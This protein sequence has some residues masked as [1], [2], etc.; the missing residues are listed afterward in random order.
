MNTPFWG[1]IRKSLFSRKVKRFVF[2]GAVLV[3]LPRG[4]VSALG[5]EMER[6]S[7]E[8]H[9]SFAETDFSAPPHISKYRQC[10]FRLVEAGFKLASLSLF[11]HENRIESITWYQLRRDTVRQV[12]YLKGWGYIQKNDPR[13]FM[14]NAKLV[15]F[16]NVS[17]SFVFNDAPDFGPSIKNG[18]DW[19]RYVEGN[20]EPLWDALLIHG[21]EPLDIDPVINTES[22]VPDDW[23]L[24]VG[25]TTYE[26]VGRISAVFEKFNGISVKFVYG[27]P[28][29]QDVDFDKLSSS[30]KNRIRALINSPPK[31]GR[32]TPSGWGSKFSIVVDTQDIRV[33]ERLK[34]RKASDS[35]YKAIWTLLE[36]VRATQIDG[37]RRI[38]EVA[39]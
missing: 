7:S 11:R 26:E 9:D 33:V 37:V 3:F 23:Q 12:V 13:Y 19:K 5:A 6:A 1:S 34:L 16:G 10:S 21:V 25:L 35:K 2:F 38:S 4:P 39:N 17:N 32:L 29:T 18:T 8:E 28:T 15:N 36:V 27:Y 24:Q 14:H 22:M 30:L 20:V 31:P